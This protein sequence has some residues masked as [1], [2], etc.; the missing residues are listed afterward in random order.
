MLIVCPIMKFEFDVKLDFISGFIQ[1]LFL[2]YVFHFMYLTEN[3]KLL[4]I[5]M[6]ALS[7]VLY[8]VIILS[9]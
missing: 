5:K 3:D 6:G 4:N 8:A 2:I 1:N 9:V 7:F